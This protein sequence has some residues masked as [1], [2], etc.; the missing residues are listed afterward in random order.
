MAAVELNHESLSFKAYSARVQ[1]NREARMMLEIKEL[2]KRIKHQQSIIDRFVADGASLGKKSEGKSAEYRKQLAQ[3][4]VLKAEALE[5]CAELM[6]SDMPRSSKM[7]LMLDA[8]CGYSD[9][10]RALDYTQAYV[11]N[12]AHL[13]GLT[14]NRNKK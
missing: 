5:S 8:G 3:R 10:A 14:I 2:K 6:L 9:I 1:A 11:R 13:N 7:V 4:K 12:Y